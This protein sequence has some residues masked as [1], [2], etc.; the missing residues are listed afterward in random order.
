[1]LGDARERRVNR[2][3]TRNN[4]LAPEVAPKKS[5]GRL[6]S[7]LDNHQRVPSEHRRIVRRY[8]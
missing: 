2:L 8:C 5:S 7:L 6:A 4:E 1:M 3:G